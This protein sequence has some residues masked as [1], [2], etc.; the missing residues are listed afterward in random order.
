MV[1]IYKLEGDIKAVE[2]DL[3][4][5]IGDNNG[6]WPVTWNKRFTA[7]CC[8]CQD[9]LE[10]GNCKHIELIERCIKEGE[11]IEVPEGKKMKLNGGNVTRELVGNRFE[12]MT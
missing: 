4:F 1:A 11:K 9:W 12:V 10:T 8:M 5:F 3:G 7:L 6:Q 2:D